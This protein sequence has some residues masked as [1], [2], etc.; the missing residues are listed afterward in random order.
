MSVK[1]LA[2][3][4]ILHLLVCPH[5]SDMMWTIL[6]QLSLRNI[7]YLSRPVLDVGETAPDKTD[8]K[9][10]TDKMT[11]VLWGK[12]ITTKTQGRKE[13]MLSE[14][15]ARGLRAWHSRIDSLKCFQSGM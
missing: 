6:S 4:G 14:H 8:F 7:D 15:V 12:Q 13:N 9:T 2:K 5:F 1:C 3:I 10:A 11:L